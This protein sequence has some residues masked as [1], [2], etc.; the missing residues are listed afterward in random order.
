M[1]ADGDR[2]QQFEHHVLVY[3]GDLY[4]AALHLTRQATDAEDLVQETC[5]RAFRALD[6]LHQLSAARAWLFSILRSTFLREIE[7]RARTRPVPGLDP[8]DAP[9]SLVQMR[10]TLFEETRR[11]ILR[12]PRPYREAVIL[13]HI[14][15]FSY[16]EMAQIL[17]VPVGTV[18]SRLFRG[19]RMLRT[20]LGE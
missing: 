14:G 12:L 2:L 18:M 19:R 8:A 4:R 6:Q 10:A 20:L 3:L 5:L 13:N 16:P 11:A 15:G 1:E 7:R 17:A 9:A